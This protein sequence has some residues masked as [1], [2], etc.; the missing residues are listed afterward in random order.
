MA[1]DQTTDSKVKF[2]VCGHVS[3]ARMTT[4]PY[5]GRSTAPMSSIDEYRVPFNS[6]C[7]RVM[8]SGTKML[9]RARSSRVHMRHVYQRGTDMHTTQAAGHVA[10]RSLNAPA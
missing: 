9:I 1:M 6:T 2:A 4:T 7:S 5:G 8:P 3:L 10:L